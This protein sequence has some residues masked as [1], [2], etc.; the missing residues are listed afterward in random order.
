MVPTHL[1]VMS[2]APAEEA[3][4]AE[5]GESTEA[6]SSWGEQS[7]WGLSAAVSL[8][9]LG[10]VSEHVPVWDRGHGLPQR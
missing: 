4:G 1:L 2:R 6:V 10:A 7:T 5:Q 9:S 3:E 8:G